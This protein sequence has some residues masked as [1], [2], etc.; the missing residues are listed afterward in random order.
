MLKEDWQAVGE[1]L[2]LEGT[3]PKIGLFTHGGPKDIERWVELRSFALLT[4]D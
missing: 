2:L 1:C 4:V 3:N